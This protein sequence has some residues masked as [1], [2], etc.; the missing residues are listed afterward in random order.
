MNFRWSKATLP[1]LA[2]LVPCLVWATPYE[3]AE[4][5]PGHLIVNFKASVGAATPVT[6][7]DGIV[8]MGIPAL[9]ELLE[10]YQVY[11]MRR[12]VPDGI[13]ARMKY[14]PDFARLYVLYFPETM[15]VPAMAST[16]AANSVVE[17][18]EPDL[19]RRIN[20][21]PNDPLWGSQ[22][23]KIQMGC[24]IAWDYTTG[25]STII[26]V[27]I[28]TGTDWNHPDLT[29]N[30]WVNPGED[31]DGDRVPWV[32]DDI[33]GDPDDMDRQDNDGNGYVDDLIGW[34]FINNISG[35]AEGEDCDD[36]DPNPF[37]LEP[38]GTHTLGLMAARGNNSTGVAGAGWIFKGMAIRA[39][40]LAND[41][42]GYMPQ[43]ATIPAINYAVAM[44]AK[45]ISMSY[46]GPSASSQERE[47]LQAAWENGCIL[48]ASA[49]NDGNEQIQYPA[50]HP[51]VISVASTDNGDRLSS[52]SQRGTWLDLCAPGGSPGCWSTVIDGYGGSSW[53]GTSMAS[54]NAAGTAALV[55]S[56]FSELTNVEVESLVLNNCQ[57]ISALN[58]SIPAN[59]LGRGRISAS[60]MISS[61]LP[62]ITVLGTAIYG[63]DDGDGR[64]ERNETANLVVSIQND[65]GWA[66]AY[67]LRGRLHEDDPHLTL[68]NDSTYFGDV[69]GD[70][71]TD[72][73]D[74]PFVISADGSIEGTYW[75]AL[76]LDLSTEDGFETSVS[77]RLR[78]E[79]PTL[80]LVA[81]DGART[82]HNQYSADFDS[83]GVGYDTWNV[84]TD[85]ALA[86]ATIG[87]YREIFWVCG[88]EDS[89]TLTTEDQAN[90]GAFLDGGGKLALFGR[91]IDQDLYDQ[92]FYAD[93]LHCASLSPDSAAVLR[94][95]TG[96]TGDVISDGTTL[97]LAGS[98]ADNGNRP[99]SRILPLEGAT[100][101]FTYNGDRGNAAIRYGDTTSYQVV[102][103][104]FA[105]EAACGSNMSTHHRVVTE[106]IL[107]WFN[108][109]L[110][111]EPV[112]VPVVPEQ[113][114]LL[115]GF[116]NPF[117]PT[118]TIRYDVRAPGRVALKV[119]D[120]Q[121]RLVQTL[122]DGVAQM[123]TH[124]VQFDASSLSSGIYFVQMTAPGF[125]AAKKMVFLK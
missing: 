108:H 21:A 41:G 63:D 116:P 113:Y 64:L 12:L 14:P 88:E 28:D 16:F 6:L 97:L 22:W 110:A 5:V 39:G 47:T 70:M 119:Y 34:D 54:P 76:T 27:A 86:T 109:P 61:R 51:H 24:D 52:W 23:D 71:Q 59:K 53:Q 69:L 81:D 15:D 7:D 4:W 2:L 13:L 92:P 31:L 40:Y 114:A 20:R 118:A 121:G 42:W 17:S 93:Y 11:Q 26:V 10:T 73:M 1:L 122:V 36:E 89:L 45:V 60:K 32:Y 87:H 49:G 56:L 68:G 111:A 18:A 83:L 46:G 37:G 104:A 125:S 105:L 103:C 48:F 33:C 94:T 29:P 74:N 102:Y 30:L 57:D 62:H 25:D 65:S 99:Q 67:G 80:L 55:W 35:C 117:N 96:V 101:I 43:S 58:P 50:G 78:I 98:C 91:R 19:L 38:H 75:A 66:P 3:N 85:G 123:G 106:R 120:V 90:L 95:L 44:G 79:W 8:S 77:L 84:L 115:G 124:S 82:Y 9:D 100:V 107:Q 72:N 112:A